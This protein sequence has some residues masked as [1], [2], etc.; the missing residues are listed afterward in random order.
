MS[1][2]NRTWASVQDVELALSYALSGVGSIVSY[3]QVLLVV[4]MVQMKLQL[5]YTISRLFIQL[6]VI[7][8]S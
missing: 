5:L 1:E 6:T 3:V 8:Y 7:I 4:I 2:A